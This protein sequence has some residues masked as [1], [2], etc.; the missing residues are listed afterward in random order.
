[1]PQQPKPVYVCVCEHVSGLFHG[2]QAGVGSAQ[3][4]WRNHARSSSGSRH[5]TQLHTQLARGCFTTTCMHQHSNQA[6][7]SANLAGIVVSVQGALL[8]PPG[9]CAGA[10]FCGAD[11]A[12]NSEDSMI[13]RLAGTHLFMKLQLHVTSTQGAHAL[14]PLALL[15]HSYCA[16]TTHTLR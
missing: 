10:C 12:R 8:E 11:N 3:P 4:R 6:G 9:P 7:P 1:M 16:R 5:H 13:L 14:L 2:L 15:S